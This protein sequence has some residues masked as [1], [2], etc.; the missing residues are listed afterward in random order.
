MDEQQRIDEQFLEI[1]CS[2]RKESLSVFICG[3]FTF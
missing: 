3:E 1:V 2:S